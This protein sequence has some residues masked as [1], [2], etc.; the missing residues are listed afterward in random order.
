MTTPAAPALDEDGRPLHAHRLNMPQSF[1]ASDWIASAFTTENGRPLYVWHDPVNP[2]D[3]IDAE[4][5]TVHRGAVK[6]A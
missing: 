3:D 1:D 6:P 5:F 4:F 2:P